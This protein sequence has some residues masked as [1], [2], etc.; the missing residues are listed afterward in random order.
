[1]VPAKTHMVVRQTVG[2][3]KECFIPA[4]SEFW[5]HLVALRQNQKES[6]KQKDICTNWFVSGTPKKGGILQVPGGSPGVPSFAT[7]QNTD[8]RQAKCSA[9][10]SGPNLSLST[11]STYFHELRQA[12][13]VV[14]TANMRLALI[15]F[16]L[17]MM[18]LP[19]KNIHVR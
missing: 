9:Q 12:Q 2:P 8:L 1:M 18:C 7:C 14:E 6:P 5:P 13:K 15:D 16:C 17:H 19:C 10:T 11:G 3:P 4:K